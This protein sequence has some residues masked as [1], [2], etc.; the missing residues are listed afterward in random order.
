MLLAAREGVY[1]WNRASDK[2][3]PVAIPA[4]PARFP[5]LVPAAAHEA[6]ETVW[7]IGEENTF[8][9]HKH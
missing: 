5:P 2:W 9:F 7:I 6:P 8:R 1:R 3:Q 4:I